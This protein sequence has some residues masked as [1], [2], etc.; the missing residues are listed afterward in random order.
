MK[1]INSKKI[2][3]VDDDESIRTSLREMLEYEGYETVWAKNGRVALDYL[4]AVPQSEL[5]DLVLLDYMMPVM[6][7][8]AFC[9]AKSQFP[10][11]A[12]IPVVMM[13]AGGNLLNVMDKCQTHG[14]MAKPMD[15]DTVVTTVTHLLLESVN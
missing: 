1:S 2:L 5:P 14:Y 8:E 15:M 13:T 9:K 3:T 11:L 6:N 7:G 10:Q 12:H 4:Q